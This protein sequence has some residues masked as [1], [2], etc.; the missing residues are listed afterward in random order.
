MASASRAWTR[1]DPQ[2]SRA[3]T[4]AR[5]LMAQ[6]S[7]PR[8]GTHGK[9]L[10][11]TKKA[12]SRHHIISPSQACRRS[13]HSSW[14]LLR[15]GSHSSIAIR[16]TPCSRINASIPFY[17][18]CSLKLYASKAQHHTFSSN[19]KGL[20]YELQFRY[21]QCRWWSLSKLSVVLRLVTTTQSSKTFHGS[22][23]C[24]ADANLV[25]PPSIATCGPGTLPPCG[26]HSSNL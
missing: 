9:R 10:A 15:A 25:P 2:M 26:K 16:Q 18:F 6:E 4:D 24:A 7:C 8:S 13:R 5:L 20:Q 21:D 14:E 17:D 12:G 1:L 11:R 22:T 3:A 19:T 23:R